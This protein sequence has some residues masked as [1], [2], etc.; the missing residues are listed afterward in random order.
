MSKEKEL[1]SEIQKFLENFGGFVNDIQYDGWPIWWFFKQRFLGDRLL[2]PLPSYEEIINSILNREEVGFKQKFKNKVTVFSLGKFLEYNEKTKIF[3]SRF[4]KGK[5]S[6][7]TDKKRIM[8]MTHTNAI[9]PDKDYG[10]TVDRIGSVVKE[11]RK[12]P[13]LEEYISVISPL[14]HKN[15]LK[16]LDY[17]NLVYSYIDKEIK[18][19][20][21]RGS[22]L[23]HKKWK[24]ISKEINYN[25]IGEHFKTALN[26]FFSRESIYLIILYYETYKKIIKQ[27]KINFLCFYAAGG[28]LSK[29][30][31]AAAHNSGVKSLT[32]S[33]GLGAPSRNPDQP[34]SFYHAVI[35]DKYKEKYIELGVNPENI[36]VTGPVFMDEIVRY[37]KDKNL[38]NKKK[39]I[40]F[41]T[42]PL[43]EDNYLS[44]EEYFNYIKE[45]LSDLK[46]LQNVD[47]KIKLHPREK[48]LEF[49]QNLL[50]S[51]NFERIT[52]V[53]GQEKKLL[54]NLI[55][56]SDLVIGFSSTVL[57]EAMIIGTPIISIDLLIGGN[58]PIIQNRDKIIHLN[59]KKS[60][61]PISKKILYDKKEQKSIIKKQ[62]ELLK[63]YLY[64]VDGKGGKRVVN[65]IK[66]LGR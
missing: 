47:I 55:K 51:L 41:A 32:I 65:L 42:Q 66:K 5:S 35:G 60:I 19:K 13:E 30:A 38:Q 22:I 1:D 28:I 14:S 46:K 45:Y 25:L 15:W 58:D 59:P 4:N 6:K 2:P 56:E 29:C 39:K 43:V 27:E 40:L 9:L 16:L 34:P 64:K 11:V 3:I 21:K 31:I 49:Y 52:I 7:K 50:K 37:I 26:V 18:K 62:R 17:P 48:Y 8:F 57:V 36:F 44:K 63:E 10:Y 33:H 61:Y 20:A 54:Y 53:K 24:E 12:D 23:L